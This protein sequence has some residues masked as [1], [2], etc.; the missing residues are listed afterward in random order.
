MTWASTLQVQHNL[1]R[2]RRDSGSSILTYG[3]MHCLGGTPCCFS[4]LLEPS[5]VQHFSQKARH[6]LNIGIQVHLHLLINQRKGSFPVS[7]HSSSTMIPGVNASR[8]VYFIFAMAVATLKRNKLAFFH[9]P[10]LD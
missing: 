2:R 8:F 7:T 1:Y 9:N 5:A 3:K 4:I 6:F 10:D